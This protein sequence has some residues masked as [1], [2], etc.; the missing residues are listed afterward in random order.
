MSTE[1]TP[2]KRRRKVAVE[3]EDLSIENIEIDFIM[4]ADWAETINGK[5]YIQGAGWDRIL[6]PAPE[7]PVLSFAIA[8]GILVPWTLTNRQ[9]KIELTLLTGDG[10]PVGPSVT[11]GFKL[12]RPAKA[13]S[14]QRMRTPFAARIG[15]KITEFGA[16]DVK[17]VVNNDITKVV[18]FYVV[19]QL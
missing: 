2:R 10:V 14:G 15:A 9:H 5:L 8:A 7:R 16:Y 6:R 11:G 4:V 18:T 17:L 1:Q 13:L 3:S 19:E 12:G